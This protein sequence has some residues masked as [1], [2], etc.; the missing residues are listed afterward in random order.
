[1]TWYP[2]QWIVVLYSYTDIPAFK[3]SSRFDSPMLSIT[4]AGNALKKAPGWRQ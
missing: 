3:T 4:K 1:M 2:V